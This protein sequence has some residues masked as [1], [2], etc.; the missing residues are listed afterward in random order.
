[1]QSL[2][3]AVQ[4]AVGTQSLNEDVLLTRLIEVEGI[5]NTKLLGYVFSDIPSRI[6]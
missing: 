4:V 1:M 3:K 5:L 2:K 6:P